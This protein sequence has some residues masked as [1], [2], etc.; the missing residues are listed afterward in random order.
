MS[1]Q[2]KA[3]HEAKD[4]SLSKRVAADVKGGAT[5]S[6]DQSLDQGVHFKYDIKGNKEA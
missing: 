2:R 5:K 1:V 3:A 4:L 6:K